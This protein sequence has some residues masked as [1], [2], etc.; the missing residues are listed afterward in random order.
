MKYDVELLN[1]NVIIKRDD[2]SVVKANSKEAFEVAKKIW[3]HNGW[4]N[5][6]VYSFSWLGRPII[7][8]PDDMV[9]AQELIWNIKPT[10][11]IETGIAHGG[12]LIFYASL[13]KL[14]NNGGIVIGIDIDVRDHNKK[15]IKKH[16]MYKSINLIEG[17][18]IDLEIFEQV[19]SQVK[20]DDIVLVF[21]DSCHT[22]NHVLQELA[23]YSDLVT[24]GSYIVVTDGVMEEVVGA[25]R[26]SEDWKWNNPKKAAEEFFK[27][28][29]RKIYF[30]LSKANL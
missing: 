4:E 22:K 28:V 19:K 25:S 2:G 5:K 13:L 10:V 8:L 24:A 27:Y 12:S 3:I 17:S 15:A 18:S 23:L 9:R 7:Q 30:R 11:I 26:T 1:N 21:L 14:I 16:D 29:G 6:Y 20:K